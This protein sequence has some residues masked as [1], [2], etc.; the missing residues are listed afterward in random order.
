MT[1]KTWGPKGTNVFKNLSGENKREKYVVFPTLTI[2]WGSEET[3]NKVS[4]IVNN[5]SGEDDDKELKDNTNIKTDAELER[6]LKCWTKLF[7]NLLYC[8]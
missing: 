6:I 5:Y 7:E 2:P 8:S 4:A 3:K 1:G